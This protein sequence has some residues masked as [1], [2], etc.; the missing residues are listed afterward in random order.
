MQLFTLFYGKSKKRMHPIMVDERHKCENYRKAREHTVQGWH[1]IKPAE[2]N[3]KIWRKG[4]AT[5]GGNK[6]ESVLRVGR[7]PSGYIGKNGFN[8]HT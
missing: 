2:A 4:S 8:A 7:G 1:D 3:A 5:V 6:C